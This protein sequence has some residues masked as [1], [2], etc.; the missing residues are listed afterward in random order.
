[1]VQYK[2]INSEKIAKNEWKNAEKI[3]QTFDRTSLKT[4]S[5]TAEYGQSCEISNS[6]TVGKSDFGCL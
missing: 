3:Y 5:F 1:M 6:E 4:D 2:K